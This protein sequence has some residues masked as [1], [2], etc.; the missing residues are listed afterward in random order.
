MNRIVHIKHS[1]YDSDSIYELV[2][3]YEQD[4]TYELQDCT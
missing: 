2:C 1:T 3:T 4:S